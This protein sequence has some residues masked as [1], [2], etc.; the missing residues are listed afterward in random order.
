M[1]AAVATTESVAL[2]IKQTEQMTSLTARQTALAIAM[3][4][5]RRLRVDATTFTFIPERII[6]RNILDRWMDFLVEMAAREA[7]V[8]TP[9]LQNPYIAGDPVTGN[10]F[11]NRDE[12]LRLLRDRALTGRSVMLIGH[13]R[14]GKSS[15]L[16]QLE[17]HT[18]ENL[19]SAYMTMERLRVA[20]DSSK[21]L[22]RV[23]QGNMT[24]FGKK[25]S[26]L[27]NLCRAKPSLRIRS[28]A[29]MR[30]EDLLEAIQPR[31]LVLCLDEY[32]VLEEKVNKG[33]YNR[34]EIEYFF[35]GFILQSQQLSIVIAGRAGPRQLRERFVR[36]IFGGVS[37][38]WVD[39]LKESDAIQLITNPVPDFPINYDSEVVKQIIKLTAGQPY[40]I[41]QICQTLVENLIEKV[42]RRPDTEHK[43]VMG[44]L[45]ASLGSQHFEQ[46]NF[47]YG[48]VWHEAGD[49]GRLLLDALATSN[50]GSTIRE[51][52]EYADRGADTIAMTLKE[53][54]DQHIVRKPRTKTIDSQSRLCTAG[55]NFTE[56]KTFLT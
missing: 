56:G 31:R 32:E 24:R 3:E 12:I 16:M 5:L 43:I 2:R 1:L 4:E 27:Q 44:D 26:C 11:F 37:P 13:R 39:L 21:F 50:N 23:M 15:I 20:G 34:E 41:Q 10:R 8:P 6:L 45:N 53:L 7:R 29:S 38:E 55:F 47:Y 28:T 18:A 35:Q 51:L 30:L 54:T 40:L 52:T 49:A 48:Q 17:R 22:Y 46:A 33:E 25:G 36:P 42:K 19:L 14:T 9:A